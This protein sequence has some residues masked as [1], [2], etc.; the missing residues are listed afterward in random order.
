MTAVKHPR[1]MGMRGRSLDLMVSVIATV[2]FLLFGYDRGCISFADNAAILTNFLEGVMSGIISAEPFMA[3]FP[4]TYHNSTWQGFVTAIYEI[5]CMYS[6]YKRL[7]MKHALTSHIG[8]KVY[9]GP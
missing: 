8:S 5:G 7:L 3:Y 4:E 2:G 9:L 1:F 6:P